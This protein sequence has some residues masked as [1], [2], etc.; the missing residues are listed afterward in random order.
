MKNAA[1]AFMAA[2]RQ[3]SKNCIITAEIR[4]TQLRVC[5]SNIITPSTTKEFL[6]VDHCLE[7]PVFF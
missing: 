6:K 4:D 7:T 2:A 5:C 3:Y 1:T